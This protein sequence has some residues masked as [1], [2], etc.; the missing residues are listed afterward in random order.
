MSVIVSRALPD[1]RDSL[2]PV[3][4]RI[5]HGMNELGNTPDKAY[6]KSARGC[7]D[8]M[9][10]VTTLM[11]TMRFMNPWCGWHKI[12]VIETRSLMDMGT[13]VQWMEIQPLLCVIPKRE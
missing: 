11:G 13:L 5:L 8:V 10:K 1:V 7:S 6:K 3:H 12:L 9:G 2:K 4:R